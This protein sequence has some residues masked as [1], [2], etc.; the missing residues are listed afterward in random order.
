MNTL[1][2]LSLYCTFIIINGCGKPCNDGS[3]S[4]C[5]RERCGCVDTSGTTAGCSASC[6][7]DDGLCCSTECDDDS[8]SCCVIN[9]EC[10]CSDLEIF[11]KNGGSD[12]QCIRT[13]SSGGQCNGLSGVHHAYHHVNHHAV[14]G[15]AAERDA[16]ERDAAER[17]AAD[18]E[19]VDAAERE[20]IIGSQSQQQYAADTN[21]NSNGH[22]GLFWFLIISMIISVAA[23]LYFK[24]PK[25]RGKWGYSMPLSESSTITNYT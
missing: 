2:W 20:Y 3:T 11:I 23:I 1:F 4:C 15:D 10:G 12:D 24:C 14:E 21:T 19:T 17:D 6:N 8:I 5:I 7:A 13:C 16:A 18:D 9:E 25:F 22:T